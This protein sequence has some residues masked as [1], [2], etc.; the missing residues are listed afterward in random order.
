MLIPAEAVQRAI[1]IA[2]EAGAS[3]FRA[4][5]LTWVPPNSGTDDPA[6]NWIVGYRPRGDAAWSKSCEAGG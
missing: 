2:W 1:H 3:G 6:G 5:V 4:P